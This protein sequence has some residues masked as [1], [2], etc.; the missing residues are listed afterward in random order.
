MQNAPAPRGSGAICRRRDEREKIGRAGV[1]RERVRGDRSA[2]AC[3]CAVEAIHSQCKARAR[4]ARARTE[5]GPESATGLRVCRQ[6]PSDRKWE[7]GR[8]RAAHE[9]GQMSPPLASRNLFPISRQTFQDSQ[10]EAQTQAAA[11]GNF[12][13]R[14]RGI[15]GHG[16]AITCVCRDSCVCSIRRSSL[17]KEMERV[18]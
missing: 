11:G 3:H 13:P 14:Q 5:P 8:Q 9:S 10:P 1:A 12:S 17:G 4:T 15:F 7:S 16:R 2:R 6:R 18:S